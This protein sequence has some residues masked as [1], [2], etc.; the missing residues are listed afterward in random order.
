M[1]EGMI[2]E[3]RLFSGN[4]APEGWFLCNGQSLPINQYQALFSILGNRYGGDGKTN[5]QLPKLALLKES[6][7]GQTPISYVI[8]WSGLY[9]M[10]P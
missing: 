2:G 5:F 6:D 9:P 4:F 7:G 10:R 1:E 3:I 8:C